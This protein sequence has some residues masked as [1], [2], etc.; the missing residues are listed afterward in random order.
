MNSI[1]SGE[2]PTRGQIFDKPIQILF[3][4]NQCIK[5]EFGQ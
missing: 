4:K 5:L 3:F 1:G 2:K